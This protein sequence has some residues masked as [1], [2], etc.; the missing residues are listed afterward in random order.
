[1][2]PGATIPRAFAVTVVVVILTYTVPIV[3][4]CAYENSASEGGSSSAVGSAK[5]SLLGGAIPNEENAADGTGEQWAKWRDGYFTTLA[6]TIGGCWLGMW[7]LVAAAL[8]T[9]GQYLAEMSSNSFQL[10]GMAQ[11]RQLP[12]ALRFGHRS[13]HGTS[14]TGILASFLVCILLGVVEIDVVIEATNCVYCVVALLEFA[15]FLRLRST[16][17]TQTSSNVN[18][19]T[20]RLDDTA[21]EENRFVIPLGTVGCALML[22]PA[23]G[24]TVMVRMCI[25]SSTPVVRAVQPHLTLQCYLIIVCPVCR[26]AGAM[27]GSTRDT[28]A[29]SVHCSDGAIHELADGHRFE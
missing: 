9:M 18:S 12:A 17:T 1:M 28:A 16:A 26:L 22:I 24:L 6:E 10:E 3:I 21:M 27:L 8:S 5:S 25:F 11:R 29:G 13:R 23:A 15:A 14:T 19:A 4:G 20:L 2:R 7:L